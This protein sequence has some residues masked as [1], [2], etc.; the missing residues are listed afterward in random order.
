MYYFLVILGAYIMG[1]SSM[2]FYLSKLKGVDMHKK[3][4]G[5]LGASNAML[6]MGGRLLFW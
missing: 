2:S 5:N 6:V 1:S 3:G 4:S